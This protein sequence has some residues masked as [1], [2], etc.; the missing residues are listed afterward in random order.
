MGNLGRVVAHLADLGDGLAVVLGID[1][2][3]EEE[4]GP[5]FGRIDLDR[6]GLCR[7]QENAVLA[8]LRDDERPLLEAVLPAKFGRHHDRS[9][10]ADSYGEIGH[11]R[12]SE[13]QNIRNSA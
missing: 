3:G 4:L 5:A 9:T 6:N 1:G 2:I 12:F 10:L 11:P 7:A 13:I 8:T